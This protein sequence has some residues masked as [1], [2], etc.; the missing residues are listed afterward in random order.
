MSQLGWTTVTSASCRKKLSELYCQL[1]EGDSQ[2]SSDKK[3]WPTF[4]VVFLDWRISHNLYEVVHIDPEHEPHV[5]VQ[6]VLD[7]LDGRAPGGLDEESQEVGGEEVEEKS[8]TDTP[9]QEPNVESKATPEK[10][11]SGNVLLNG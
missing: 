8:S 6:Q 7:S 9:Q 2:L 4:L 11:F 1:S 3:T 10:S 5:P